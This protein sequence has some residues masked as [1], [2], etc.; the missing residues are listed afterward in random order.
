MSTMDGMG[1]EE[2]IFSSPEPE[3]PEEDIR[4]HSMEPD[5]LDLDRGKRERQRLPSATESLQYF[6]TSP[7]SEALMKEK[8]E[9][10]ECVSMHVL[11]PNGVDRN[12]RVID[13]QVPW[14]KELNLASAE[15][16]F[17]DLEQMIE[18]KKTDISRM[19]R[20]DGHSR[21]ELLRE[22][23]EHD[24]MVIRADYLN[25]YISIICDALMS[26]QLY[27]ERRDQYLLNCSTGLDDT[28]ALRRFDEEYRRHKDRVR[29]H[30]VDEE[31]LAAADRL[32]VGDVLD[33]LPG[34]DGS[35]STEELLKLQD[36]LEA[37]KTRVKKRFEAVRSVGDSLVK[38]SVVGD[39][40]GEKGAGDVDFDG[41]A[42]GM[43]QLN[44]MDDSSE[45]HEGDA[46]WGD[47]RMRWTYGEIESFSHE[48]ESESE[49]E[50]HVLQDRYAIYDSHAEDALADQF[51][52]HDDVEIGSGNTSMMSDDS[53]DASPMRHHGDQRRDTGTGN[54][55][56]GTNDTNVEDDCLL[57]LP[58]DLE[59]KDID[60]VGDLWAKISL[61]EDIAQAFVPSPPRPPS[62]SRQEDSVGE[63]KR[64]DTA[65]PMSPQAMNF[66][67]SQ[68]HHIM[69]VLEQLR[70]AAEGSGIDL[71]ESS[72]SD[73]YKHVELLEPV[74]V[75]AVSRVFRGMWKGKNVA[76]K[77]IP[78]RMQ[79][80]NITHLIEMELNMW[81]HLKP[82]PNIVGFHDMFYDER[83][84][85]YRVVMEFVD[86]MSLAD[87]LHRSKHR[88]D[89]A[90][91][92]YIM[93]R[94]V[95]ALSYIHAENII[96]R[97]IKPA[98]ILLSKSGEVKL[99]D[100]GAS[101]QLISMQSL[102]QSTVG[103]VHYCAPEVLLEQRYSRA[104][105]IWGAAC[106]VI[107]MISL[108]PP[109]WSDKCVSTPMLQIADPRISPM[110]PLFC[111]RASSL[112]KE[113]VSIGVDR[114]WNQRATS[115]TWLSHPFLTTG[116]R[117]APSEFVN[118]MHLT[119]H[120]EQETT[121]K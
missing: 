68:N 93:K 48:S 113:F 101:T 70:M 58:S 16:E 14:D 21:R 109:Y 63:P 25:K 3:V 64:A 51:K 120:V 89:E 79:G 53:L 56:N 103:T 24:E 114:D 99:C 72:G 121:K 74:G 52:D 100:F 62:I 108:R 112:L 17:G 80:I 116:E 97:D 115:S 45:S 118:R 91:I 35:V 41:K 110:S 9:S 76:I 117:I 1:D 107:E 8:I 18:E 104:C 20:D 87:A 33:A 46:S 7:R 47:H 106:C 61:D 82:H 49:S 77:V 81:H 50:A 32:Q 102:R 2:N 22:K 96:H 119:D 92:R 55:T 71:H 78:S 90:C 23:R 98:N 60:A 54:G 86:G 29:S 19:A 67:R 34:H 88:V 4:L 66:T 105:D 30:D 28:L 12:G 5:S 75:G 40:I 43:E 69:K 39:S 38:Q 6:L 57:P 42:D 85:E 36:E 59:E 31:M 94:V 37:Y 44:G 27:R 83:Q 111:K 95:S 13:F 65:E 73:R 15:R 10:G 26:W 11:F 84:H